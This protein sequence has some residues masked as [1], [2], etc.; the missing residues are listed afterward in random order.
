[1]LTVRPGSGLAANN[2][3]K[4]LWLLERL[5]PGTGINNMGMALQVAGRLRPDALGTAIAIVFGRYNGLRTVYRVADGQLTK[6][7]VGEGPSVGIERLSVSGDQ[8][9][10]D[11]A[12]FI[13]RP[14]ELDGRFLFRAGLA[15]HPDGDILC[16]AVH[17]FSFDMV[18]LG[19]FLRDL[20]GAYDASP[21]GTPS[22]RRR[23]PPCTSCSGR[24]GHPWPRSS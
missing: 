23:G 6:E 15:A 18:S 16:I 10:K 1:M 19:V 20:I 21:C 22:P 12:E 3:E 11:V 7:V 13:G 2:K 8:I 5:V 4:A 9:E 17:H 14:F 24:Y